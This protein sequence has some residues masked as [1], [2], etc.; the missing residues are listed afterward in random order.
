MTNQKRKLSTNSSARM[1][2]PTFRIADVTKICSFLLHDGT[3]YDVISAGVSGCCG[4]EDDHTVDQP[5][6]EEGED[7]GKD[8]EEAAAHHQLLLLLIVLDGYIGAECQLEH[9]GADEE[10][11]NDREEGV[12]KKPGGEGLVAR[13]LYEGNDKCDDA[14]ED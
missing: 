12:D 9:E 8:A 1:T 3:H 5:G 13:P 4:E 14:E 10:E 7:G 11:G 6:V 2:V